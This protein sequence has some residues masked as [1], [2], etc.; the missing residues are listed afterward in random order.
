MD[1]NELRNKMREPKYSP[2]FARV[3]EMEGQEMSPDQIAEK[4]EAEFPDLMGDTVATVI[5]LAGA[6]VAIH[7]PPGP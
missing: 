6:R 1:L 4:L 2:V 5:V 3:K 7:V